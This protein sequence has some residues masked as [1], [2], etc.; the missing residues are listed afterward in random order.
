MSASVPTEE[1]EAKKAKYEAE[2]AES[3]RDSAATWA[4]AELELARRAVRR[5]HQQ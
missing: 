2:M 3:R 4:R 1:K 5:A